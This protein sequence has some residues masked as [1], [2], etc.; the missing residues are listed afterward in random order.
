MHGHAG[1]QLWGHEK[2]VVYNFKLVTN[3]TLSAKWA[4]NL[5]HPGGRHHLANHTS[6]CIDRQTRKE[7]RSASW[8]VKPISTLKPDT[9]SLRRIIHTH[10]VV[11]SDMAP[12]VTVAFSCGLQV[13]KLQRLVWSST[14]PLQLQVYKKPVQKAWASI[15]SGHGWMDECWKQRTLRLHG[16]QLRPQAV[17]RSICIAPAQDSDH[18]LDV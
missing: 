3:H 18:L 11:L 1:L 5:V 6:V 14:A 17:H 15:F 10:C 4:F 12:S 7:L 9:R 13:F 16:G 8:N 2:S